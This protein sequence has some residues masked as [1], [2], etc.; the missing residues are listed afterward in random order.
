[1]YATGDDDAIA[2]FMEEVGR[3]PS[4][5]IVEHVEV[6]DVEPESYSGFSIER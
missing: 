3:G 5:A 4:L 6:R 2:R 1:M